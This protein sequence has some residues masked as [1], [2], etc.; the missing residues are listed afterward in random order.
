MRT[1]SPRR[2]NI[3]QPGSTF[4]G[5]EK[6]VA[7][8]GTE[9][10]RHRLVTLTGVGGVGKTRL[11]VE[12]ALQLTAD[13]PDGV[14]LLELAAVS[15]PDAVPGAVAAVFG[16]TQQPG[17]SLAESVADAMT[18]K[19]ELLIFDNCEHVREVA[20]DLIETILDRSSAVRIIAT[21][22]EGLDL[23]EEHLLPVRSLDV[24]DGIDSAAADLFIDRARGVVPDFAAEDDDERAMTVEICRRLDGIPLA[25]ELAASRMASMTVSEVRDRLDQRF[26]LLVGSRRGIERHQTL[27]H[28]VAWSFDL[29][30]SPEKDLLQRC[31]VFLGGFDLLGACAVASPEHSD[32]FEV[33][34][35]LDAL[36]RQSLR[37]VE[38]SLGRT[39]YSM[40]E[41]I[42]QFAEDLL[43]ANGTAAGVRSAHAAYFA[44][45]E[46]DLEALWDSPRQ[47]AAYRWFATELSNI[48]AAFRWAVDEG[49]LDI[50]A[51]IATYAGFLGYATENFEPLVWAEELLPAARVAQHPRLLPL[52]VLAAQCWMQG[53]NAD[54]VKLSDEVLAALD[55]GARPRLP[56]GIDGGTGAAYMASGEPSRAVDIYRTLIESGIDIRG[57][58]HTGLV[59]ALVAVGDTD[60]AVAAG[61]A[62]LQDLQRDGNPYL[63]S[64]AML[65]NG[66]ALFTSDHVGALDTFRRGAELAEGSGNRAIHTHLVASLS[67]VMA[68]HGEPI[69]ALAQ[70]M[71]AI[72]HYISA[73]NVGNLRTILTILVVVLVRYQRLESA[74]VIGGFAA[75]PFTT[76]TFPESELTM[77]YLRDVLGENK[78]GELTR[79][80]ADMAPV[81][82]VGFVEDE[83]K[84]LRVELAVP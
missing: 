68:Y 21:S 2:G 48:R 41:T 35:L 5:R 72:R 9:V 50:A 3:R 63:Q 46:A 24:G 18:G 42:R 22:R 58:N 30:D 44:G 59:L 81:A 17:A 1:L 29:L 74:A 33:L 37:V 51:V 14:W 39:R 79:R 56:F 54:A 27:R 57:L 53:R 43:V 23:P 13:F 67:R 10:A 11:A 70:L 83:I 34:D 20:A 76:V 36:V 61:A 64:F 26:R 75:T 12:T 69:E 73:G 38:R 80:G 52:Q 78:F 19:A 45:R 16:I 82:M 47:I 32:E 40:L 8:V 25:I 77:A 6:D 15:D 55:C 28:T 7:R 62:L 84:S 65:A 49:D 60:G 66:Y 31:S 4:V 71:T